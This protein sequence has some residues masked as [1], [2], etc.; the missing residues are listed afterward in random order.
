MFERR[1]LQVL[2]QRVLEPRRFIQI[3]MGPRQV[4]KTTLLQQLT[5]QLDIPVLYLSA[6][7][8]ITGGS[9]WLEQ[10]WES[11]RLQKSQKSSPSFLLIIDE[12]QKIPNWSEMVKKHWDQD[13]F[14]KINLYLILS[15]SSRRLLEQG[16]T[17]SLAGRFEL[18]HMT[19]W[20]LD[21]MQNAFGWDPEMYAIFGGYPGSA[22][23]V[24][25]EDRWKKYIRDSMIETSISKDIM[26]LTRIDKPA[27]L[28]NLFELGC[29]YAGHILSYTK[30]LG[31]LQDVGNTTTLSHYL[32]L[33]QS[34][35]L[36]AGLEKYDHTAI[37]SRASSPKLQPFNNALIHAQQSQSYDLVRFDLNRW[38][39]VVESA[40]GAHLLNHSIKSNLSLYYWRERDKEVDFILEKAGKIVAIEVKRGHAHQFKGMKAFRD[41]YSPHKIYRIDRESLPWQEFLAINPDEL[42]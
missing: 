20:S 18:I 29:Q 36:I 14:D 34:A 11:A 16:L 15:G 10:A 31:Q 41:K 33:L 6:D 7:A 35:G 5:E 22:S 4:G 1:E 40:V 17:E 37:R 28:K 3:V 12:V 13:T 2:K 30:M 8:V 39:R 9:L 27:L 26:M 32:R 23:L 24:G 38:G 42:F 19:H 21:E 25:D